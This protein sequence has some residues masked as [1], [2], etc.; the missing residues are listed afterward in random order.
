MNEIKEILKPEN[1]KRIIRN[2][3][4]AFEFSI[5]RYLL[6]GF[7]T[8]FLDYGMLK[9][10]IIYFDTDPVIANIIST[11]LALFFNFTLSNFW[12]FQ[13]GT[14]KKAKKIGKYLFLAINNY[15]ISVLVFSVLVKSFSLSED[16][17]KVL[18]TGMVVSWNFLIYKYWVFKNE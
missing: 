17:S 2:P 13:A 8:F 6:I 3:F 10:L 9:G 5:V 15:L 7:M 14:D 11:F 1:L 18:V 4:V 16:I 12:T